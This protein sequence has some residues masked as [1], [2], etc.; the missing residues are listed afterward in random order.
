MRIVPRDAVV[1]PATEEDLID[2]I[3]DRIEAAQK[4]MVEQIENEFLYSVG[5]M[6]ATF[7][8]KQSASGVATIDAVIPIMRP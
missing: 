7:S 8:W 1:I 3:K 4:M 2:L 5:G 6:A